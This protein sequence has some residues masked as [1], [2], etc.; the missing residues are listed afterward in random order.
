MYWFLPVGLRLGVDIAASI[1]VSTTCLLEGGGGVIK[2]SLF[3]AFI[4]SLPALPRQPRTIY[5]ASIGGPAY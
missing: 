2:K 1:G 3:F 5:L 4:A